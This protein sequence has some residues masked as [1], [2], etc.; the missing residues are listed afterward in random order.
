MTAYGAA[1]E[2]WAYF[3]EQLGLT[4]DLLPYIADPSVE[5]SPG[6]KLK[7][8]GKVPS[9]VNGDGR[10]HGIKAWT[11][12][13]ASAQDIARW[14]KDD[15]HGICCIGRRLRGIDVD[16]GNPVLAHRI[17]E[18][19]PAGPI[20]SRAD[21]GKFLLPFWF[22]GEMPKRV[23]PVEGGMIEFLGESQQFIVAGTHPSGARYDW[24]DDLP[25]PTLDSE[26]LESLWDTL[27]TCYATGEPRIARTRVAGSGGHDSKDLDEVGA[28]LI[29]NWETYDVDGGRVYIACPFAEGH[30]TGNGGT[31]TVYFSAGSGGYEQ[32]HYRCLHAHCEGRS[33][34]EFNEAVGYSLAQFAD[35]GAVDGS[36]ARRGEADGDGGGLAVVDEGLSPLSLIRG[37]QGIEPSADNMLKM[38]SAPS[39][40]GKVLSFDTFA[41]ELVWCLPGE[42]SGEEQWRRF[43]DDD[44][45]DVRVELER[46]GTRPMSADLLRSAIHR[47]ARTREI[48]T[49]QVWLSRLVWDGVPRVSG[50][51]TRG[52]GWL[53]GPYAEAV[54]RYIWS[55]LAGRVL[56]PGCQCDMAPVLVGAQGVGKTQAIKAMVPSPSHYVTLPLDAHDN[57]TARLLRGKLVGELEELRGLNS[58]AIE[59]IKAWVTKTH[60]SWIVKFKEFETSFARRLLFFG[61]TNDAEFLN[62]PT[63]ERRF[64]PG[65]CGR[66]DVE[67]IRQEREQLWA[68]GAVLFAVDGV[69]WEDAQRL[70]QGEHEA[71]KVSDAW[72]QPVARWLVEKPVS[73][74]GGGVS[75]IEEGHVLVADALSAVGVPMGQHDRV[76]VL[77][78]GKVLGGMGWRSERVS[79][80]GKQV[81]AYVYRGN[82]QV[83]TPSS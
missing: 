40:I 77:R 78:M 67:W 70:G 11:Q 62:D 79:L 46:R 48:D 49:A 34:S 42:P 36:E 45:F 6:S 83:V 55:G 1:P 81:R 50:F 82:V 3:S 38:C 2:A 37:K 75:P 17:A 5:P 33:D 39:W 64:L 19:L 47:A 26:A 65:W 53:P 41:N 24:S 23:L 32:G 4:E 7:A 29:A 59:A 61:T 43:G 69:A 68:E 76:K 9:L 71:F 74:G 21:S 54:S 57:D 66:L 51:C 63:G 30:S 16:V 72:E 25:I 35:L 56:E 12:H 73:L 27:V 13:R 22:D 8:F 28:W 18:V 60:E 31:G 20:R 44:T 58:R 80:G 52:W 15:R 14:A 10:G